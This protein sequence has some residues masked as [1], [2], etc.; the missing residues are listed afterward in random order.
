M[1]RRFGYSTC[2]VF[3]SAILV[4]ALAALPGAWGQTPAKQPAAASAGL[5]A[6]VWRLEREQ[7]TPA[8]GGAP[9]LAGPV[10]YAPVAGAPARLFAMA[11]GRRL[12]VCDSAGREVWA[13]QLD[14][15]AQQTI[16][17]ADI[18]RDRRA[19]LLVCVADAVV[20]VRDGGHILWRRD[21]ENILGSPV[22]ADVVGDERLEVLAADGDGGLTCLD[23]GGG[24]VWH[25]MAESAQRPIE[26]DPFVSRL[27][28]NF[29]RYANRDATAPPAVGDVDGDGAQEILLATEP[30]FVYCLS[31][32]GEWKWQFKAGDKCFGAPVIADLDRDGAAEVIVG[33]DDRHLYILDGATGRVRATMETQWGI[34]PSIAV[35][36][37]D[38]DGLMEITFGD[39]AGFLYCCDARG[40]ERW[41]IPFKDQTRTSDYGD[42]L[43]APP[44]VADVD[45]DGGLELV[46]GLRGREFLY[47]VSAAG[48]VEAAYVL[49]TGRADRLAE[50]GVIDTPIVADLEGHGRLQV[51]AATRLFTLRGFDAAGNA[52]SVAWA[53]ARGTPA[54][55]ACVLRRCGGATRGELRRNRAAQTGAIALASSAASL[56]DGVVKASVRRPANGGAALLTS[57]RMSSGAPELRIDQVLTAR[58]EFGIMVPAATDWPVSLDCAEV[59]VADGRVLAAASA[60]IS[61]SAGAARKRVHDDALA[62]A[63]AAIQKLRLD[64]PNQDALAAA[65]AAAVAGLT[66]K[67]PSAAE[68][69]RRDVKVA[70]QLR[71]LPAIVEKQR[72]QSGL[73][74]L[75]TWSANP[76]DAFDPAT[77]WPEAGATVPAKLEVSL[78]R[79]EYEAAAVNLLN[80]SSQP[81]EIRV[82]ASDL[83][84]EG[85]AK[86]AARQHIALRQTA[87]VPRPE[88]DRVGDA[89]VP[90]NEAGI[91]SIPP[92]Q[93]AQLWVTVNGVQAAAGAY[94]G[95]VAL[96]EMTPR[97]RQAVVP[98]RA[99]V[100]PIALPEKSPVRFCTWAYPD[101]SLFGGQIAAAVA[102]LV[103]HKNTVFTLSATMSV[104]YDAAGE[105]GAPDWHALD[106]QLDRYIGRGIILLSEPALQFVG[107]GA[108]PKEA[109]DKAYAAAMRL[110]AQHLADKGLA[111]SDWAIYVVDEPGL[112]HGPR[113]KYLVEHGRR[114]K[115]A[116]P[117]IQTYADPVVV[118]G[119]ADLKRAA[120]FVDIWCPEQDSLYRIWGPTADMHPQERLAIMRADSPQVWTYECFPRVKRLSPLGYYRHQA[121][122]AW[123]LGLNGLGFWTYCTSPEDPWA[124]TKDEFLLVYP[125]RDG[126]IP[127]K[128]WEACRD[129]VEDYEALWLARQAV[130]SAA[131]R[132]DAAAAAA[133]AEIE[134]IAA[135]VVQERAVWP[136]LRRSRQR[137]AEITLT[138]AGGQQPSRP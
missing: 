65:R 2:R 73:L 55:T 78:Y 123:Q 35:A 111:Y 103:A 23:S 32:R 25:L 124:P 6:E 122:L 18:D 131:A 99:R 137:L 130:E 49:E 95:Q 120:P 11:L 67:P 12:V 110:L 24:V 125:G 109:Y 80:L 64:W 135:T 76:W 72:A 37:L 36:D 28:W 46:V 30:G 104:T 16:A 50:S 121:W 69:A 51:V 136:V 87:M 108:A 117:H 93:A 20:C 39:A 101:N 119:L 47:V 126:P 5:F 96:T 98:L 48:K 9:I 60:K 74:P 114:I 26:K 88:G 129:G 56:V 97:G 134:R 127:S 71:E 112:E 34:T 91:I 75:V 27:N 105:L 102:D 82:A 57:I 90:L 84:A 128:R 81:L 63:D 92:M 68:W 1:V 66:A 10:A 58:D 86:L 115:A 29:E 94:A 70:A 43:V 53:G 4:T 42:R 3:A 41:R 113:I 132:G 54:L 118:M 14:G 61:L 59:A 116:D 44:A 83:A 15:E 33:S 19:E 38:R 13:L 77:A 40:R 106:T 62:A 21:I 138:F 100:W 45:G 52:N 8:G 7:T 89:L 133:R 85:G 31:G 79:G 17:V 107:Q 22:C